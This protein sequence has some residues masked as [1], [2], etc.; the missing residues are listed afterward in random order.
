[1][2][3]LFYLYPVKQNIILPFIFQEKKQKSKSGKAKVS[4]GTYCI[5]C[6]SDAVGTG[7]LV[8]HLISSR[9]IQFCILLT[10]SGH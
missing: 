10:C 3:G 1:M 7:L 5:N 2:R 6:M 4:F 8:G 9:D